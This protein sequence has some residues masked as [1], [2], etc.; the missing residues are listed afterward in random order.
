MNGDREVDSV[1]GKK[2]GPR[3]LYRLMDVGPSW[4]PLLRGWVGMSEL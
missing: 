4:E 3:F 1:F 2:A